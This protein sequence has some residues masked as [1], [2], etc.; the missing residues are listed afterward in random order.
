MEF[1]RNMYTI[2]ELKIL[3]ISGTVGTIFAKMIGGFD[4]QIKMLML[5][6]IIDYVSGM[7]AAY[8]TDDVSSYKSFK[9]ILKKA[10][11]FAVVAFCYGIDLMM[12]TAILRYFVICGYGVMEIV[13]IVENADRGG[14]GWIF[15]EFLRSK[16]SQIKAERLE[17]VR[18]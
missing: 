10:T 9:G 15:P 1:I 8:K 5:F 4:M 18:K 11:I 3:A 7:Y 13:S 14:W 12:N 2:T 6:V 16:L 17:G